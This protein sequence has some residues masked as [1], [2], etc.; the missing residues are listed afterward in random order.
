MAMLQDME[1]DTIFDHRRGP[2]PYKVVPRLSTTNITREKMDA[3]VTETQKLCRA[4]LRENMKGE[5]K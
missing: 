2:I 1:D 5:R 4:R 3:M